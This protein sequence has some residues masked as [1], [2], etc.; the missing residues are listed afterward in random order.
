MSSPTKSQDNDDSVAINLFAS[1]RFNV[2]D[3]D[4]SALKM[5]PIDSTSPQK[6]SEE[7]R[8]PID[9]FEKRSPFFGLDED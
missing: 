6:Q 9:T 8:I 1:G 5:H 4:E 7:N 3:D 2:G